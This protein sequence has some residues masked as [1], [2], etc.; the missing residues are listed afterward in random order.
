MDCPKCGSQIPD[1]SKFCTECG[2]VLTNDGDQEEVLHLEEN[3]N[4]DLLTEEK[5][6]KK[7]KKQKQ[8]SKLKKKFRV[9]LSILLVI[10]IA[11]SVLFFVIKNNTPEKVT[12]KFYETIDKGNADK[13][14][15]VLSTKGKSDLLYL[16]D[17]NMADISNQLDQIKGQ[18]SGGD[19]RWIRQV[20]I[21]VVYSDKYQ[22][23]VNVI[24]DG[25]IQKISLIKEGL[26]W[27]IMEYPF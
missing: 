24:I 21:S 5:T 4:N 12:L 13:F 11:V 20:N 6:K 18:L 15:N 8:A 26:K 16:M 2:S 3:I 9:L 27:K 17:F 14:L 19:S 22:A 23:V 7:E 25:N 10:V 1:E